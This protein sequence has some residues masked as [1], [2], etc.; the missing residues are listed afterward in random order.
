MSGASAAQRAIR[1][2]RSGETSVISLQELHGFERALPEAAG[3]PAAE[4]RSPEA[5]RTA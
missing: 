4:G 5:E 1:S 3:R 2:S